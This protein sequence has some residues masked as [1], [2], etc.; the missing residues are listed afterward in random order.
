[1]LFCQIVSFCEV[2]RNAEKGFL[3]VRKLVIP[4]NCVGENLQFPLLNDN[5]KLFELPLSSITVVQFWHQ[6]M[7]WCIVLDGHQRLKTRWCWVQFVYYLNFIVKYA[8]AGL[9]IFLKKPLAFIFCYNA[10]TSSFVCHNPS[11]QIHF[12][13]TICLCMCFN[14]VN[15]NH[16]TDSRSVCTIDSWESMLVFWIWTVF[17]TWSNMLFISCGKAVTTTGLR[18]SEYFILVIKQVVGIIQNIFTWI[19]M[20]EHTL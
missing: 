5:H 6:R 11:V 2:R 8:C 13:A 7:L 4:L 1:M 20:E 17:W 19:T 18:L 9:I 15:H 14:R 12:V 10:V 16:F 3:C